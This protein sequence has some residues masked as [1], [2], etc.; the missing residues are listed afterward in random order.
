MAV[1]AAPPPVQQPSSQHLAFLTSWKANVAPKL[2]QMLQLLQQKEVATSFSIAQI[3]TYLPVLTEGR[4]IL[5]AEQ[6]CLLGDPEL[7]HFHAACTQ[8]GVTVSQLGPMGKVWESGAVQVV[9]CAESLSEET[10][11]RNRLPGELSRRIA[12][13]IYVP[14]Y[15]RTGQ[16]SQG[17]LAV[18]ELLVQAQAHDPMVVANAISCLTHVMEALQLSISN[19]HQQQ[20]GAPAGGGVALPRASHSAAKQAANG[21]SA[22]SVGTSAASHLPHSR[23]GQRN[24]GSWGSGSSGGGGGGGMGRTISM[25]TFSS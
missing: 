21:G 12:E 16:V 24:N 3:W 25:H 23:S 9:Q 17:V 19:P 11:P 14:V 6:L 8:E 2:A 7:Q 10:H 20:A 1:A 15:D 13:C 4:Q 5:K 18:V 22:S